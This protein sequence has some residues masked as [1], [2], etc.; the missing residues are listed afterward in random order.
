MTDLEMTDVQG[1]VLWGY[2]DKPD[3]AYVL[4]EIID[5]SAAKAWLA[6]TEFTHAG[7]DQYPDVRI[8]IAFTY[9]GLEKLGVPDATLSGFSLEFQDGM[10]SPQRSRMLGDVYEVAPSTWSWGAATDGGADRADPSLH[11]ILLVYADDAAVLAAAVEQ[12]GSELETCG[13]RVRV[14]DHA[15][16]LAGR[17]EHFGFRDGIAQPVVRGARTGSEGNTI[18]PGEIVLGYENGYAKKPSS[19]RLGD[20]DF[21]KNGSYLVFRQLEQ[22]VPAFWSFVVQ[23]A[24]E[25]YGATDPVRLAAKMVGRWPSGAPLV[26][27]PDRDDPTLEDK[28]DFGYRQSDPAG[29]RCPF[30]SHIRRTNPRDWLLG[31][32]AGASQ[33]LSKLHRIVRR[34]RPYGAAIDP[35]LDISKMLDAIADGSANGGRRGLH[36]LCFQA[37]I[38][39]QFEFIQ[40]TWVDNPKFAELYDGADPVIG[41]HRP[42][43]GGLGEASFTVQTDPLNK[44]VTGLERF[45]RVQGGAYF[46]MPGVRALRRLAE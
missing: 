19:P 7:K 12:H 3:S 44:R 15:K 26:A 37:N 45:V 41:R 23:K 36:F 21:G 11:A 22:D 20:E 8:N 10:V 40:S 28:D 31:E 5:V 13:F 46:F 43:G 4:L 38:S 14:L 2:G 9:H 32:D 29:L 42:P 34:G 27:A 33:N 25:L 1:I 35:E 16:T 6:R 30:G 24:A 17:K 18:E 39:R